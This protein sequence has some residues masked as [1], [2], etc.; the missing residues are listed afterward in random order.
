MIAVLDLGRDA[1]QP[2]SRHPPISLIGHPVRY[3]VT[4]CA[5]VTA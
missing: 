4:L 2:P 5:Y 1:H 3:A